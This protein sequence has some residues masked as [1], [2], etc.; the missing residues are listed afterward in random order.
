MRQVLPEMLHL[1]F[2]LPREDAE[3]PQSERL[4][5]DRWVE[6]VW[7]LCI[8]LIFTSSTIFL[9]THFFIS[10]YV[11]HQQS[12]EIY[13]VQIRALLNSITYLLIWC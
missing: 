12:R 13:L 3:V 9:K 10:P 7:T 11:L 8:R 5:T 2:V 6:A 1:L 4:Y